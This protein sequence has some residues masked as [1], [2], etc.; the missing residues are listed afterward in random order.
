M[1]S[2]KMQWFSFAAI[3]ALLGLL[4][5]VS[6]VL[7]GKPSQPATA[8]T[9]TQQLAVINLNTADSAALQQIKGIG[10]KMAERVIAYRTEHGRFQKPEELVNVKGIGPV[11][12][13]RIKEQVTV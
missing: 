4:S 2:I 7:A 1:K 6:P 3:V 10:P 13:E 12:F 5:P 11:K 9:S 8:A